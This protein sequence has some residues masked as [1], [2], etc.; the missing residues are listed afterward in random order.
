MQVELKALQRKLGI[1]FMLV[2]HDQEE[3]LSMSDRLAVWN[4]GRIEQ[5]G[6]P[7]QIYEHPATRFV[8]GFVGVSNIVPEGAARRLT[9]TEQAFSIRPEKI[10]FVAGGAV[11]PDDDC[12][13]SAT[14]TDVR[15][16]G[17]STR[18]QVALDEG[19]ELTVMRQ[20]ARNAAAGGSA[21]PG[22]KVT[23]AWNRDDMQRIAG[24]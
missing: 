4:E 14:V 20:N 2:T 15:Y 9:G 13:A 1:T 17:A 7:E 11:R 8:A 6:S 3:A 24:P 21:R 16:H 10:R 19:G 12:H 23:I 18:Y 22:E 5:I